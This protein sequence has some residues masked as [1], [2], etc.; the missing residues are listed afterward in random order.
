[1][2]VQFKDICVRPLKA[3]NVAGDWNFKVDIK[4]QIGNPKFSLQ[5][6]N[7]ELADRHEGLFGAAKITGAQKGNDVEWLFSSSVNGIEVKCAYKGEFVD[8]GKMNGIVSPN[9]V[10][11]QGTCTTTKEW[12]GQTLFLRRVRGGESV[13]MPKVLTQCV[14]IQMLR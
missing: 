13:A 3:I 14:S 9:D 1:M 8:F 10:A 6:Q 12:S 7:G 2:K 4:R 5:G 11:L